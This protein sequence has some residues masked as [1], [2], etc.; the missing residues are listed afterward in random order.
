MHNKEKHRANRILASQDTEITPQIIVTPETPAQKKAAE[1]LAGQLRLP[2]L[3]N[4]QHSPGLILLVMTEARLE[5]RLSGPEAPG[6]VYADF[7]KGAVNY[8]RLHGGGRK[9]PLARAVRLKGSTAPSV[10]DATAGLGRDAFV[11]AALGCNVHMYERSPVI[12]ALLADGLDR[13][14]NHP[15][16]NGIINN[17]MTLTTGDIRNLANTVTDTERPDVVYLDPMYPHRTKSALVKKEMRV[18]RAVVGDDQDA[19]GLLRAGLA[20]TGKRVV[21]KRPK[22][23]AAIEGPKPDVVITSKNSRFDIYLAR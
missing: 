17:R 5:L 14:R 8:R 11:L 2:C 23:A 1:E 22:H 10:L 18:L 12:A 6:P 9:Q 13:A 15:E 4:P 19:P 21:V 3:D 16:T 20:I 7:T